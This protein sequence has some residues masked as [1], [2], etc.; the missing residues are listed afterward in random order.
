MRTLFAAAVVLL[1]APIGPSF[2]TDYHPPF[3][4]IIAIG[5]QTRLIYPEFPV[6]LLAAEAETGGQLGMVVVYTK[7]NEGTDGNQ[8]LEYKLTE[9]YY[10]LEG[11]HRFFVGDRTVEGGPGTIVVNPP[12]VPHGFA[13]IG[14][15]IGKL[16][17]VSTPSDGTHGTSFFTQWAE[18]S[19]RTPE[20]IA[21]TNKAYGIDRSAP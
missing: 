12:K 4:P 13:Y 9:V 14:T 18:Q 1:A 8:V 11:Q 17:I 7:P 10:V 2:A 3:E 15:G 21:K 6:E 20:W 16:L 19:T 5:G